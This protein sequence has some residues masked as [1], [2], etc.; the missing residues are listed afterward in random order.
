MCTTARASLRGRTVPAFPVNNE[1]YPEILRH[2][3]RTKHA[4]SSSN[5]VINSTIT[6]ITVRP[7]IPSIQVTLIKQPSTFALK[8]TII[9]GANARECSFRE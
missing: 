1:K 9:L 2:M 8:K 5:L 4:S 7:G 3:F 6:G